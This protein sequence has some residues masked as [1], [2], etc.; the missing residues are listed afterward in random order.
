MT[1]RKRALEY[2]LI[3]EQRETEIDQDMELLARE[4]L[5]RMGECDSDDGEWQQRGVDPAAAAVEQAGVGP[6]QPRPEGGDR[7]VGWF[8][9]LLGLPQGE[10]VAR[11]APS[12]RSPER[13]RFSAPSPPSSARAKRHWCPER[14]SRPEGDKP[15]LSL[16]G[17]R[18]LVRKR[19]SRSRP[20]RGRA[21]CR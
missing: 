3:R 14:P 1:R 5:T 18:G 11:G 17:P 8:L 21:C 2:R 13:T 10:P 6:A 16:V 20:A 9:W 15:R 4:A 7:S 19:I 12:S